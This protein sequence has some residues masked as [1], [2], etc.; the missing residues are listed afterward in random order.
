MGTSK[1][2]KSFGAKVIEFYRR[3]SMLEQR[4]PSDI[5]LLDPYAIPDI[6]AH[7]KAFYGKFFADNRERTFIFGINPGRLGGG[8][9][10]VQFTDPVALQEDCG[11]KNDLPQKRELSSRFVY[12]VI[13][14]WGGAQKFYGSFFL[15]AVFPVGLIRHG[16][17]YNYYDDSRALPKILPLIAESIRRQI[18]F[19]A[20]RKSVI[21]LGTG[22]NQSIFRKINDE[23]GFFGNVY[24]LE[25]PRYIMQYKRKELKKYLRKYHKALLESGL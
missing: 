2:Q 18:Q 5:E 10:G 25:H 1:K 8:V 22:K 9:T 21:V 4:F 6:Q 20:N 13:K 7:M 24:T 12:E 23:Y 14:Q 11:I 16:S 15:T 17:N 19:G 3:F